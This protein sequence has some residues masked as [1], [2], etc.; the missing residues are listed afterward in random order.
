MKTRPLIRSRTWAIPSILAALTLL[1]LAIAL[2][3]DGIWDS[4]ASAVLAGTLIYMTYEG[5]R[6]RTT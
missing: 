1:S 4:L 2:I 5:F 3:V 6:P